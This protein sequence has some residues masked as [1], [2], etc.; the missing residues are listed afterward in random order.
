[1]EGLQQGGNGR[2]TEAQ[3]LSFPLYQ[4]NLCV[5][6]WLVMGGGNGGGCCSFVVVGLYM[7]LLRGEFNGL[8][9]ARFSLHVSL[10]I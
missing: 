9:F 3:I 10:C 1:M 5:R 7:F 2:G 6:A 4:G 8:F